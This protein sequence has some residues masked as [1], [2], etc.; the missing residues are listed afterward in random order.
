[1]CW[2]RDVTGL[3]SGVKLITGAFGDRLEVFKFSPETAERLQAVVD[4]R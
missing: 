1:M 2:P 3:R 4:Q